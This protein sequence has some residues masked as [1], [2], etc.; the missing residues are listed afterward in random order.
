MQPNISIIVVA[1]VFVV[2]ALT[3]VLLML[4]ASNPSR[5]ATTKNRL[6]LLHR[7]TGYIFVALFCVMAY[8][9]SQRLAGVGI[10]KNLPTYLVLHIVLALSLVPLLALKLVIARFYKQ[11]YSSLR[12]L[13]VAIFIVAFV[14]VSIPAFSELIRSANPG[15]LGMKVAT[16]AGCP[17]SA[18]PA[19]LA[20]GDRNRKR[21]AYGCWHQSHLGRGRAT[22]ARCQDT[23][24]STFDGDAAALQSGAVPDVSLDH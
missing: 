9:M 13:G 2:L 11:S 7:V 12:A 10:T 14:A 21:P 8:I 17:N 3:N 6:I 18:K 23:A 1:A 4:D 5:S 22:D 15:T 20:T 19:A 16:G 24:L